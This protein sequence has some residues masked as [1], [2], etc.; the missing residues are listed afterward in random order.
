MGK[1]ANVF[2]RFILSLCIFL[3]PLICRASDTG[4]EKDLQNFFEQSRGIIKKAKEKLNASASITEEIAQLKTIS[5]K[6]KASHILL[7]ER[8][9]L[10]EDAVKSLGAKAMERHTTMSEG[11]KKSLQEYLSLMD[12]LPAS[13]TVQSA[14]YKV[15]N[16]NQD[17][18]KALNSVLETL[19]SLLDKILPKKKKPIFGSLPYKN[20]NYPAKE[21][22]STS[23]AIKPAYKGGNKIVSPDDLKSTEEAPISQEIATLA[24]SLNWS[25]VLIYEYVKN[26]IETE[27]Y[28]GCMKGAEETLRQKS[29][30]DCD[31]SALLAALLRASGYPSRYIRGTMEF[32]PDISSIKNNLGIDD[33]L[34]IAEFL[35]KAGIPYKP[36]IQGGKI[37][38]FQIERIW[39]ESQ[40]PYGNYR[41]AIID[42]SEKKWLGLDTS[43]KVEDYAYNDPLDILQELSLASLRNEYLSAVQT[44]TPLE[45]V[46]D[47]L[48]TASGQKSVDNYKLTKTLVPEILKILP[49]SLQFIEKRITHEYTEIPEELKHK[50]RF[51]AKDM[52]NVELLNFELETFKLSNQR[53]AISYEPET[54]EDQEIINSYGGLDNTP[55]YLVKLRPVLKINGERIA[56]A[57][58]GLPMGSDYNLTIELI[59]PNGTEKITNTHIVG[60]LSVIGIVS[61][62][63]T[64]ASTK[65]TKGHE[66]KDAEQLLYE[67]A[68]NYIDR[69]NSAEEEFASLMHLTIARPLPSVVT[70]GGVLDVTCLLDMPHGIEWKGVFMDADLRTIET[71]QSSEVGVQSE[72]Q[73]TFMQLSALQ[74]S[75]LENKIF[76]DDFQVQAIST[77]KL[78]TL[79]NSSQVPILSIDST[80]INTLLPT[81]PF[82]DNI[83]ED[84]INAVNQNQTVKIP[85]SEFTYLD[86]TGTGYVKENLETGE[87]GYMLSGMIA[88]GMTAWGIDKWPEYYLSRL[89][90]PYSEPPN[91]DPASARYIQKIAATDMQKG[92]VGTA[93]SKQLQ[94]KVSDQNKKAVKKAEVTFT[95]KA[96]GGSLSGIDKD[97]KKVTGAVITVPTN[98]LGIASVTLTLGQK[99]SENPTFWWYEDQVTS[100]K[101]EQIGENL[102]DATLPSGAGI[103]T[104]FTA[105]G[106]PKAARHMKL[107]H[108]LGD[109]WSVVL[110]FAGFVSVNVE[111]EYN[112][113]VSNISV[114]FTAADPIQNPSEPNCAWTTQDSRKTY[115]TETSLPCIKN[116][117]TW[118]TCGDTTKQALTVKTDSTG[119]AAQV[120]MGGMEDAIYTIQANALDFSASFTFKTLDSYSGGTCPSIDDPH[121]ELIAAYTYPADQYGNSINA[122]KT[123]TTI[124][125]QAK[126]YYLV[127][128]ETEKNVSLTCGGSTLTCSKVVGTRLYDTRTDFQSSQATFSGTTGT[129]H[130][131]GIYKANYTLQPGLNTIT[132]NG[133]ATINVNKTTVA[134]PS[135][136]T[137]EHDVPFTQSASITMQVY[138]VDIILQNPGPV[139]IDANGYS[140]NNLVAQ[141]TIIP[142]EYAATTAFV[143]ILKNGEPIAYVSS[144]K[145][146]AGSGTFLKGLQFDINSV[147]EAQI[148]LNY[149]SGVEIRSDTKRISLHR[150]EVVDNNDNPVTTKQI[151]EDENFVTWRTM[152]I[153]YKITPPIPETDY[154]WEVVKGTA[155]ATGHA[156]LGTPAPESIVIDK[157][158][159][160]I[161]FAPKSTGSYKYNYAAKAKPLAFELKFKLNNQVVD[162]FK[163]EQSYK[164]AIREEYKVYEVPQVPENYIP[165]YADFD[166]K[167][168]T[169]YHTNCAYEAADVPKGEK[170]NKLGDLLPVGKYTISSSYRNPYR[171]DYAGSTSAKSS[172][173]WS[174]AFDLEDGSGGGFSDQLKEL[175]N[176]I[177]VKTEF[178]QVYVESGMESGVDK[179]KTFL[180]LYYIPKI[181]KKVLVDGSLT[182]SL[183]DATSSYA[184]VW[185]K[186]GGWKTVTYSWKE[187]VGNNIVEHIN[188]TYTFTEGDW[189][190]IARNLHAQDKTSD[191]W[192]F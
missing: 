116:S 146:G 152:Q 61:Q 20:L 160:I 183:P 40:I 124:P 127:E 16:L 167:L 147:Y 50:V 111:D 192:G 3:L 46:K 38:N 170:L 139:F 136:C 81:L 17:Q 88:G 55:A 44:L 74:G 83:K 103:T 148:V 99:T 29:G 21:P 25:P 188:D 155:T 191:N 63:S 13:E 45:Y 109:M 149:G 166:G 72:R 173:V 151:G 96:G 41:G 33:P 79:A 140:L 121:R 15:Q 48:L 153:K 184:I 73:K 131:G 187:K 114:T 115:L 150:V 64:T 100:Q 92:T 4:L 178:G 142:A 12:S 57:T 168:Q 98:N 104:P 141:Y 162:T 176:A 70:I 169:K 60:N 86:W 154:D 97:G 122:G 68:I 177:R 77:A 62:K 175:W 144:E 125:V 165:T 189:K 171:N 91:Y 113:P 14:E 157:T 82:D 190:E 85:Q 182:Y 132:I 7:Q 24:Q 145:S 58:D 18:I 180:E 156:G 94:V 36:V 51:I 117:P 56:V 19:H 158:N 75:I 179:I 133:V 107:V 10:R 126:I 42:N 89:I 11:Y 87:A 30:N 69:W 28:Y 112:N 35:Q 137:T 66:D 161:K 59:S 47:K 53:I 134:C 49:A 71:V 27:W 164:N 119:A 34:K 105:Y 120:V 32:F 84:I 78:I 130:G 39:I 54:V 159:R 108:P 6:I 43:I 143:M 106:F 90:N 31:Q 186:T 110:S 52:N 135:T 181:L 172:H 23:P 129:A 26:N 9:S 8:F 185:S 138:G 1:R 102:V 123:G 65:D 101:P 2:L 76:E 95:V 118:G 37:A 67:E 80:N 22:D 128:N 5:E 93:V 163:I 174:G